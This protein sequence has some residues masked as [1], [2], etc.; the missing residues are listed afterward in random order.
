M[1]KHVFARIPA[2]FAWVQ[3]GAWVTAAIA[4]AALSVG[5]L[6]AHAAGCGDI[7][8]VATHLGPVAAI[9]VETTLA[10]YDTR[11]GGCAWDRESA[12]SLT[13]VLETAGDHGLDPALFHADK[14]DSADVAE[15]D[16]LMTDGAIRFALAMMRGFSASPPARVDRAAG[17]RKNGDV[18]DGLHEALENGNVSAWLDALAPRTDAYL[19]LRAAMSTYRTIAEAGGWEPMP[20]E[21]ATKKGRAAN[22][23]ALRRRLAMEGD[24]ASDDGS[25]KWDDELQG[26]LERFQLRNGMHAGKLDA[27]TVKRLNISASQRVA[28][29][30]VN[31]ERLRLYNHDA[32]RTRIEVNAPT[33]T[34]V[35]YRDGAPHLS[36]NAVVGKPGHDTPTL[37][38][39]ITTIIL[40]PTW[41]VP[42]S[43]IRNEIKPALKRNK[44]YLV[45]HRMYWAGDQ[46]VQEPGPHNAL[47]RVK[48]DFPNRYSVY[49]H[50]T[51]S[52]RA[53][54]D[55]ERAQSH[56]CVR[57]E[58]PI[59][60]A[61]ELLR[62]D[63]KWN[64]EKIEQT[65]R[66]GATRRIP[67]IDPMPVVITYQTAY[68]AEDGLVN[69]RPDIYGLDT[70][71]TL[72]LAQRAT[73]LRSEA[74]AVRPEAP[75]GE[76]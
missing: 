56:G 34:A 14:L 26:A 48:F 40:N 6:P 51:P 37:T 28:Q 58:K 4:A 55:A 59:D 7:Q 67:L 16:V 19:Q 47:G 65:I 70:Q 33:A 68:V 71:L 11:G 2:H 9:D 36:M 66:D 64:R 73:A 22:V 31:L 41:T 42:Q 76:F 5:S 12:A 54:M 29:I 8:D 60:L 15:R 61:V 30:A 50:D 72:A 44:N 39:T 38:S 46:L 1:I 57:L 13:S 18:I 17:S 3:G 20:A 21:L 62:G 52:R 75:V 49:L 27:K 45:K 24:L 32:A 63:P 74:S 53:F 10:F 43:I 25:E 23:R 35:L 69:F